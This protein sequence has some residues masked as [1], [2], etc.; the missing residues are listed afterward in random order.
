MSSSQQSEGN[1]N[2]NLSQPFPIVG[3]GASAGGLEALEDFFANVSED[4]GMTY[5][6]LVHS[7]PDQVS[8]LPEI[9]Q[10]R[11]SVNVTL[12]TNGET[13]HPN[14]IY[15]IPPQTSVDI[16]QGCIELKSIPR[17]EV[18]SSIDA[19]FCSLAQNQGQHS[20]GV[21]LSG[22]GSDGTLGVKT[23][24][25]QEGLVIAQ[26]KETAL[27]QEMPHNAILTGVVDV[28]LPP[29]SIPETIKQYFDKRPTI[30]TRTSQQWLEQIFTVLR[31]QLGNDFSYYKPNTLTR[32][33]NRRMSL[34]QLNSYSEY[35]AFLQ[36]TPQEAYA[37]YREFLIGVTNFFR[38]AGAFE[39]LQQ[40]I[41]PT[42]LRELSN[43]T[44][45]VWVPGCSTGEEVY[46]IAIILREILD[47][48]PKPIDLQIFGTDIDE[49]AIDRAR[50]GIFPAGIAANLSQQRLNRFFQQEGNYYRVS[51]EI[52]YP[53]VFSVQNLLKDPPFSRLNLLSCRNLLIYLNESAQKKLLPLFHYTLVSSGV[54]MLGSSET[55]G[56]FQNLFE[57]L[58]NKWKIFQHREL[59][60]PQA[61]PIE[62]PTG[63]FRNPASGGDSLQQTSSDRKEETDWGKLFK[64]ALLEQFFPTAV[65]IE[66]NGLI[67]YVQGRTGKFLE[68]VSGTP[69]NNILDMAREGLQTELSS[70]IRTAASSGEIVTRRHIPVKSNGDTN[71]V[72][73]LVKPLEKPKRLVGRLLVLLEII[74]A[75]LPSSSL[76]NTT[77]DTSLQEKNNR[78]AELEKE[79]QQTRE[80][81]QTTI[82]ELESSNEEL[83]ATNEELESSNE[84]LQATNEEL[85][86]SKEELQSLNEEL[87]TVNE[88]LQNKVDELS[89]AENDVQNFLNSTEFATLFVDAQ[90]QVKR[91]T[92]E[93]TTLINLIP[94]DIGRPVQDLSTNLIQQDLITDLQQVLETLN[95]KTKAVQTIEKKW[96]SMQILPYRTAEN[97]IEGAIVTFI[98]IDEWKKA[99]DELERVNN[100]LEQTKLAIRDL[101][102]AS[103]EPLV[104]LDENRKILAVS[105]PFQELIAFLPRR[106]LS[107]WEALLLQQ[108]ESELNSEDDFSDA[109]LVISFSDQRRDRYLIDG[110]VMGHNST[111]F[112]YFLLKIKPE[113]SDTNSNN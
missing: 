34:Q 31:S 38:D 113:N 76:E 74:E 39:F 42:K 2:S 73:L 22:M 81:H 25:L 48:I 56:S 23:I 112:K 1:S 51:Q 71:L 41:L 62:F 104:L 82:E 15:I 19:F 100:Q 3:I 97:R 46:S 91:F 52:R 57:P 54:L 29:Q 94:R 9:L 21:I 102:E 32:R 83:Q 43:N 7:S 40:E 79:L 6:V 13:I 84:E 20:V 30:N 63:A 27:H 10:R 93:V 107:D 14:Q 106:N 35:L 88:E 70:A 85:E 111:E 96:Y 92:P 105:Q 17:R 89:A 60:Q 110:K 26:S 77:E 61:Q 33:I 37:L 24:K 16:N 67:L 8:L 58:S 5:I 75:N 78:I 4:S 86:S 98:D 68:T 101:I 50:E 12:V 18:L 108:L 109:E 47:E 66:S 80:N 90:M 28:I 99:Q 64:E 44:F 55:I 95:P 72:K 87:Q 103:S 53:V 36:E 45:R 59:Q 65:L 49:L 11:T 69:T